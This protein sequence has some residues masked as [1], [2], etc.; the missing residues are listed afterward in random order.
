[1]YNDTPFGYD[2][3]LHD[4]QIAIH[5]LLT[6]SRASNSTLSILKETMLTQINRTRKRKRMQLL[7]DGSYQKKFARDKT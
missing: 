1:M 2:L 6:Q 4:E 7:V 5:T 3:F